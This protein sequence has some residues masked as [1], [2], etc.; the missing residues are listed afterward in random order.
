MVKGTGIESVN[1]NSSLG[2]TKQGNFMSVTLSLRNKTTANYFRKSCQESFAR[3]LP[4]VKTNLGMD[5]QTHKS[6][7]QQRKLLE[8]P[9][10]GFISIREIKRRAKVTGRIPY[11]G[12]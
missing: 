12:S 10:L 4:E 7:M 6:V 11:S 5:I 3:Q 9:A 1:Y 8:I 2:M